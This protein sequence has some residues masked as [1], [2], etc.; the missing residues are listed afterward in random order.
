MAPAT[1]RRES[2]NQ[3]LKTPH[4]RRRADISVSIVYARRRQPSPG[5]PIML[6]QKLAQIV[7]I[8][9]RHAWLVIV[10]GVIAG[11]GSGYYGARHFA[12]DT[13]IGKLI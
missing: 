4:H 1:R 12:I 9:T 11:T 3:R 5:T 13:D 8:C 2:A 10:I 6:K 7:G